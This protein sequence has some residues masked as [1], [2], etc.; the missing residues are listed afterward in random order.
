MCQA[1]RRAY[2]TAY[3]KAY[4]TRYAGLRHLRSGAGIGTVRTFD[5]RHILGVPVTCTGTYHHSSNPSPA[6]ACSER[7]MDESTSFGAWLKQRRKA[8][9]L[10]QEEL[11]RHIGCAT[12]TLQKIELDERRPSKEIAARLAE[13]LEIPPEKRPTFL[14]VARGEYAVDQLSPSTSV[15]H[16]RQLAA[17]PSGTVT[18]LFTDLE[19]ST[20][21]WE[22]QPQAMQAALA[23]H[24]AL[25]RD[26]VTAHG[27]TVVKA[28]GDGGH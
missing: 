10:T 2:Q 6:R 9:D 15:R 1:Y 17:L 18:W 5:A 25:L 12:V 27:G 21:R 11:A 16:E 28:T 4:I 22:H 14:R 24:D 3:K 20:Q 19:Q 8:L 7:G 23:R 13:V 26:A